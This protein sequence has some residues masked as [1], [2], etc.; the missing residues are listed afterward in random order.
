M[1]K[2]NFLD[3]HKFCLLLILILLINVILRIPSLFDPVS[4]G[5][6]CIY[7]TLG[8]AFNKGLVFYRDIHDNKPPLLYFIAA[9]AGANLFW[10]RLVTIAWNTI[11]V[12]LI[13]Q[14][15]KKIIKKEIAGLIAALLFAIFSLLPEGRIANGEIYMIMPATLGV[16]LGLTAW[17]KKKNIFWLL[18]GLMFSFAFLFKVPVA[19]DF[20][21]FTLAMF[22]FSKKRFRDI[23]LVIKDKGFYLILIGF[24]L[25]IFLT[26]IYYTQ[27][28]AFT[29]YVRSALLQNVGYLSSWGGSNLGLYQRTIILLLVTG[30]LCLW[31]RRLGFAFLLPALMTLFGLYGVFLSERPY[32]HYLIEIAPWLALLLAVLFS[33]KKA[34][35]LIVSLLLISLIIAG[36]VKFKF[37][38]YPNI[39]YYQNFLK[40]AFGKINKEQYF[41]SFGDKVLYDYKISNYLKQNT[42]EKERVFIWGDGACIYAL[43]YRL[44]PGRYM[45]NY[46]IFDFNGFEE[47]IYAIKKRQ[48]NV[49]IKLIDEK[50]EFPQLET[51]LKRYYAPVKEI[52]NAII[53]RL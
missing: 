31:R 10:F 41:K 14:L 26:I 28:G 24:L 11:N 3:R 51:T 52:E 1:K 47:T 21:G 50:R 5:D 32:P 18:S 23:F 17:E 2:N 25:P 20:V 4:Y 45:V 19:F 33:Q 7:L 22:A 27:K 53:F 30:L 9:L 43:S 29:P 37:W 16:L 44:P 15:A 6:E 40:F 49:I 13:Y 35:Q 48:P 38:W 39:P 46:H 12:W 8:N 36:F 34:H 42:K